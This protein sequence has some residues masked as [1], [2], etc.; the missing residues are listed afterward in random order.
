MDTIRRLEWKSVFTPVHNYIFR[1]RKAG[2]DDN[3]SLHAENSRGV[4]D[5]V[6]GSTVKWNQLVQNGDFSDGINSWYSANISTSVSN[7]KCTITKD[8]NGVGCLKKTDLNLIISTHVYY[9]TAFLNIDNY[10][11]SGTLGIGFI[12]DTNTNYGR[13]NYNANV[14]NKTSGVYKILSSDDI[15]A[16]CIRPSNGFIGTCSVWNVQV[17]D[18]TALDYPNIGTVTP[19]VAEVENWLAL[20]VGE[21]DYYPYDAGS[22]ISFGGTS[23]KSVGFNQWDGSYGEDGKYLRADGTIGNDTTNAITPY[24]KVFS[25]TDYYIK[26]MPWAHSENTALCWYDANKNYI[27]G[28]ANKK[29]QQ[30]IYNKVVT[31]PANA[32]YM[33]CTYYKPNN[34]SCINLS[35]ASRNGTYAPPIDPTKVYGKVN[36]EGGYVQCFPNGMKSA[37]NA[38][39]EIK[40]NV[41]IKRIGIQANM[42]TLQWSLTGSAL[43]YTTVTGLKGAA[44]TNNYNVLC[45]KYATGDAYRGVD[46]TVCGYGSS[47]LLFIMD[48]SYS[49]ATAFKTAMNGVMLYYELATPITYTD[50]M[51]SEDGGVTGTPLSE[52]KYKVDKY[53]TEE[54]IVP[55]SQTGAP[56][57]TALNADIDYQYRG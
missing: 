6:Y 51:Y 57:S 19:T 20:N 14:G 10:T 41:A 50:L 33:R 38:Y 35:D 7:N 54:L 25:N 55:T 16:F 12:N 44:N 32:A 8:T 21:Q 30:L 23:L 2:G 37:G 46:K 18:L 24:I 13:V 1:Y 4:V 27:S 29:T 34:E 39:D 53:S 40:G 28:I 43:F 26:N 22:L 42:G 11:T 17:I 5:T 15:T 48:S 56:T 49:D 3:A 9:Y 52:F 47:R 31:S 36:G 45:S